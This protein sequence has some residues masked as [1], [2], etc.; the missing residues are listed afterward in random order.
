MEKSPVVGIA[1][2][3]C[4]AVINIVIS[5]DMP[6]IEGFYTMPF[7]GQ[8]YMVPKFDKHSKQKVKIGGGSGFV[9]SADGIVLTNAHVVADPNAE[10]TAIMD[11]D[12]KSK[13]PIKVLARDQI[14]D[15]AILKIE[16]KIPPAGGFPFIELGDSTQLE[17][18]EDVIVVGYALGEFR[19]TVSTGVVSGLSRFIQAQTGYEHHVERLRGL[20]QTD[21][22]INPGNSGGPLLNM[23]GKV[24]GISTAVVFG[25]QNIGFAIPINHAKRDLLE[26]Q[27][28]GHVCQPFLGIRYIILDEMVQKQNK[29]PVGYGAMIIRETLGEHAVVPGSSAA[30]AGLKEFDIILEVNGEKITPDNTIQDI[31]SKRKVGEEITCKVLADGKESKVKLKLEE[32]K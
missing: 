5:K 24:V 17:L 32:K 7:G 12:E 30:K 4:P 20:I 27:K 6:I 21:A 23:E 18:G 11:H 9:V 8:E 28:F 14:H 16:T 2:K 26:L 29:L 13:L 15:I 31:I 10:Y 19:N 25:A 22:A 1:K 3:A